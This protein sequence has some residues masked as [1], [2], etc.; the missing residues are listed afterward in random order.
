MVLATLLLSGLV[1][2]LAGAVFV[3]VG[4]R[5]VP[6]PTSDAS[7]LANQAFMV[8]WIASGVYTAIAGATDI[9][10]A[11]GYTPYLAFLA[12][13]YLT[14]PILCMAVGSLTFYFAYLFSGRVGWIWPLMAFFATVLMALTYHVRDRVPVGVVVGN[15][16]VDIEYAAPYESTA[17]KV[18]VLAIV[19]PPLVGALAFIRLARRLEGEE[20][21]RVLLVGIAM[22]TWTLAA[23][24]SR[25]AS[26]DLMQLLTR[27]VMGIVVAAIV[28]SAYRAGGVRVAPR[29]RA[30]DD[31]RRRALMERVDK[32]V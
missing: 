3:V 18:I 21:R 11:A 12:L 20:R 10:A 25:L 23:V 13:R 17:F 27:P 29:E 1:N 4:L 2:V 8:Y 31:A 5:F 32:L 7:R 22:L 28:L 16:R 30:S 19:L 6:R 26:S 15:W 9:A 24:A 14:L